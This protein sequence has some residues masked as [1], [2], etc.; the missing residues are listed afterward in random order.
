MKFTLSM[1]KQFL[2]TDAPLIEITRSLTAI[3][4]EVEAIIDRRQEL[5]QFIAAEIIDTQ[6]HPNANSLKICKVSDGTKEIQIVCGAANARAGIKVV[7]APVGSII[8]SN[9]MK[10]K[11]SKIRDIESSGML[12][13]S[14]ELNLGDDDDGI[15]EMPDN[16]V[17]GGNII[18]YL[19]KDDPVIDVS[20]TPN[21]GDCFGVYGIARDLAAK[22]LG[23]LKKP[24]IPHLNNA[25]QS[26]FTVDITDKEL[27]SSFYIAEIRNLNNI[28][29]PEWLKNTLVNIGQKSISAVVDITNYI[30]ICYAKPLHSY[31]KDK[32]GDSLSLEILGSDRSFLA[33][34]HTKYTLGSG[35]LVFSS[36]EEIIGLAGI[37]GGKESGCN[38]STKNIILESACFDPIAISTVGRKYDIITDARQRFERGIDNNF[39]QDGLLIASQM[40]MEICGGEF[41]LV[42]SYQKVVKPKNVHFKFKT[43]QEIS[44]IDISVQDIENILTNLGLQC[45]DKQ[46]NGLLLAVPPW[47]HDINIEEDL[48][49]EVLR[50][51]GVDKIPERAITT[52]FKPNI[53]NQKQKLSSI[54]KRILATRGLDEVLTWSFCNSDI[55]KEFA[56][57]DSSMF[58]SNPISKDLD[59]IRPTI[60]PNLVSLVKNALN[61][62]IVN[63]GFFEI[64]PIFQGSSYEDERLSVAGLRYGKPLPNHLHKNDREIDIYDVKE[65]LISLIEFA[66]FN[67]DNLL[68]DRSNVPQYYHPGRSA[69]I[70]LGRNILGF[71]GEIHPKIVELFGIKS[72]ICIFELY[73]DKLP[74]VK[75]KFG[76]RNLF[77][78]SIYQ[79]STRDFAFIV[80]NNVEVGKMLSTIKS[81]DKR[82]IESANIFDIY[83][84]NQIEDGKKS[85]A[86]E[87]VFRDTETTMSE[88]DINNVGKNIIDTISDKFNAILRS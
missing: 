43:L 12:C 39:V 11:K 21:R 49:E 58:I 42:S 78:P 5:D 65:D 22:G 4:I 62:N 53:L 7:L 82:L 76:F 40:I 75:Q 73:I 47:R 46:D 3:G 13:S 24:L 10:I 28:D 63:Q 27:C 9:N 69:A 66:G 52:V 38:E 84:G 67:V 32:I 87:V 30:S 15:I 2:E 86:F 25:F 79:S 6:E 77:K 35:D 72:K 17:V 23:K 45:I 81:V 57:I 34:N 64:G 71:F 8:P 50:I 70:K 48:V 37:I 33:L 88:G 56:D 41:S 68:F 20:I 61:R 80:E 1:L 55:I 44:G 74:T 60:I 19:S 16:A 26:D 29:S 54:F 83:Q 18:S 59:Y 14:A 85:V 51:Y 36:N 31:D